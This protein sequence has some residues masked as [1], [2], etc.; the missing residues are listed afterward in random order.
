MGYA[1]CTS[2][3]SLEPLLLIG[4]TKYRGI[5]V[6]MEENF[7]HSFDKCMTRVLVE[8]DVTYGLPPEID[9]LW[10]EEVHVQK[11]DYQNTPFRSHYYH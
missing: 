1:S 4:I 9:I 8:L 10:D 2:L 11:L 5:F 7:L 3:T 6:A